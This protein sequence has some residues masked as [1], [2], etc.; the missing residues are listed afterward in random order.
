LSDIWRKKWIYTHINK[1]I[2]FQKNG[3]GLAEETV[4]KRE[5]V[6]TA[7]AFKSNGEYQLYLLAVSQFAWAEWLGAEVEDYIID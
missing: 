3:G 7:E 1:W 5:K 2:K 6:L 4:E